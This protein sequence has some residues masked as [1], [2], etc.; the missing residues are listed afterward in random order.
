VDDAQRYG[1]NTELAVENFTVSGEPV[2]VE[3][4]EALAHVKAA[5]AVANVRFE[6]N[7]GV[8]PAMRDAIV[9][10]ADEVIA[11][12]HG[13]QFPVD[14]FQTG[15]GTS[16]NM[17]V[18][19]VI[20]SLATE[21]LGQPVHPND[22]VNA[23]Q[24]TNDTFPTA[25]RLAALSLIRDLFRPGLVALLEALADKADELA[26][27]VKPG[28]THLMDATP[29]T[30]GRE[31][32]GYAFQIHELIE[33]LDQTVP[34]LGGLPL[35]GTATG[36]GI[37]APRGYAE[38]AVTVLAER[39]G[40]DLSEARDH[41]AVQGSQDSLVEASALARAVAVALFKI[42]NDIRWMASGPATGLAEIT[43]PE[44][45]PGSSIMPGKVNPV[46]CEVVMQVA[47][48]VIGNDAAIAF[49]GTQ[50]NLE[51]NVFLPVIGRNLLESIKLTGRACASLANQT[52]VGI[53][54]NHQRARAMAEASP[55]IATALN[56]E[57]GYEAAADVVR[58][59][60]ETGR[61]IREVV[62]ESG[63]LDAVTAARILDIDAM[64]A[65]TTTP[66]RLD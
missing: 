59:S 27:V 41:F 50:G 55:A 10:A 4:I 1:K 36:T 37:N 11:G 53:D 2:A 43:V 12:R 7:T 48:Q 3:L 58:L 13:E 46:I 8:D 38:A 15:S 29:V 18:N 20:A 9:S 35:G 32:S 57:I 64:A 34:R 63:A 56:L 14:V 21:A 26:D 28:R 30:I 33:R 47:A 5:A 22:H 45:Q 24:S 25:I 39:T 23:S 44:L 60:L 54:A 66:F 31:F 17:N 19:E 16:T 49:A 62:S 51:L 42:A 40:H 61:S 52:V 6:A 65:G